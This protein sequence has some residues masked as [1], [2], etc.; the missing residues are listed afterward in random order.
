[1]RLLC[2]VYEEQSII[3]N[4]Q[5]DDNHMFLDTPMSDGLAGVL[6]VSVSLAFLCLCLIILVKLLQSIFK[7]RIAI[8]M[9]KSMNL[10]FPCAPGLA[11]YILIL[12]G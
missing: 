2:L 9:Q 6:M 11:N 12:E 8:M 1:M 10:E 4:K 3:K 5:K 7:G